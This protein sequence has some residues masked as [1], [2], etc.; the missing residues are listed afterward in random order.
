MIPFYLKRL[1]RIFATLEGQTA[2][3]VCSRVHCSNSTFKRCL[4]ALRA[5]D[6]KVTYDKHWRTYHMQDS[7]VFNREKVRAVVLR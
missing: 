6:V 2:L 5:L 4:A 1:L 7:G 3:Q